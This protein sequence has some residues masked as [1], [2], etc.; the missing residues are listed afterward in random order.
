MSEETDQSLPVSGGQADFTVTLKGGGN[1]IDLTKAVRS[2]TGLSLKESREMVQVGTVVVLE[3]VSR[4]AA[5]RA[6]E[7]LEA[8]GG[9]V[10]VK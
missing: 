5:L 7:V 2:L 10:E 1:T 6:K 4:E 3:G 9:H 8:A